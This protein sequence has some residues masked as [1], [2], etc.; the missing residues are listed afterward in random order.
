MAKKSALDILSVVNGVSD[1]DF[2]KLTASTE[3]VVDLI[4]YLS[5]RENKDAGVVELKGVV[6]W[7]SGDADKAFVGAEVTIP[8]F[9][10]PKR[11][12]G[13][14]QTMAFIER[15]GA[16][17]NPAKPWGSEGALPKNLGLQL[18]FKTIALHR[19]L[20]MIKIKKGTQEGTNFSTLWSVARIDPTT[21][22]PLADSL[23]ELIDDDF[24]LQV[25]DSPIDGEKEDSPF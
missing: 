5:I 16:N 8:I 4:P 3:V 25:Q 23:P 1:F 15:S 24:L 19:Q 21:G 9:L 22:E 20:V 13:I 12:L 14:K 7:V 17:K 6:A 11:P 2:N 10:D 18:F